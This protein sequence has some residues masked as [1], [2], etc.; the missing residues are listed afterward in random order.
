MRIASLTCYTWGV[1][2]FSNIQ[3]QVLFNLTSCMAFS[4]GHHIS[5]KSQY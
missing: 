3:Y 5:P 4:R 1:G 2:L